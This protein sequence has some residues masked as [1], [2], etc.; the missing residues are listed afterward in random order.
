VGLITDPAQAADIVAD[1]RSDAVM[2]AR[3]ALR[4]PSWPQRAAHELGL[5]RSETPYPPQYTRGAWPREPVAR[6]A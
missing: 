5:S 2:L 6:S 3:A 4:E 1:G